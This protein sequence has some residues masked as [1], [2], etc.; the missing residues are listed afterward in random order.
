[1]GEDAFMRTFTCAMRANAGRIA[2]GVET[3]LYDSRASC[4]MTAYHDRL[5]YFVSIVPKA[6]AAADKRYFQATGK[7]NLRIKIPNGKT[8]SSILLTNVLYCPEMGLTL[9]S[10]SKLVDAGFHSHFTLHRRIF[11]ERKKV[12]GDIP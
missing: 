9:I 3:E 6:I 12:I 10:I 11:D 1:L 2:K 4:H 5:E 7:G 8:T